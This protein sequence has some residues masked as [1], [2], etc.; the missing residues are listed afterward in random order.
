MF[1]ETHPRAKAALKPRSLTNPDVPHPSDAL[2][3]VAWV[4][5][6]EGTQIVQPCIRARLK[7]PLKNSIEEAL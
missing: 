6:T 2:V 4:G 7:S 5:L 1:L 3:F